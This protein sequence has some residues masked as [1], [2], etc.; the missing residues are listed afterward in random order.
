MTSHVNKKK[1]TVESHD[2][3]QP[4]LQRYCQPFFTKNSDAN[5]LMKV[6]E[7]HGHLPT[8]LKKNNHVT[9]ENN[10][11]ERYYHLMN[12]FLNLL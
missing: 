5:K 3:F 8:T 10:D 12:I 9:K 6:V 7:S 1:E 2:Y 11:V 4:L